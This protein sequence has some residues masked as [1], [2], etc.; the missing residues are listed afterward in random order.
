MLDAL[1]R[2]GLVERTLVS[3]QYMRSLVV[4]REL[5][6]ALR[7][8]WSVPRV[9]KD[10][11]A[12]PLL[13]L[14]AYAGL[15]HVRRRLPRVA[16]G[17][18]RAGRCDALMTHWRL[19]SPQLVEAVRRGRRRPLR[20]DG[21]R[22]APHPRARGD[23][24]HRRDHER[25]APVRRRPRA[26]PR[27]RRVV[28]PRNARPRGRSRLP[29]RSGARLPPARTRG[30]RS[31]RRAWPCRGASSRRRGHVP[32][33]R[34]LRH[35]LRRP[36][37]PRAGAAASMRAAVRSRSPP[38]ARATSSASWRCSTTSSR[39]ATVEAIDE[40]EALAILGGDMR[41]LMHEHAAIAVKLAVVARATAAGGER[42]ARQPVLPDRPEPRRGGAGPARRA[43]AG[44]GGARRATCRSPPRRPT[45]PSSPAPRASP[46]AA[47]SPC[48]SAPGVISQGRG[49]LVVHD[50]P[51][52]GRLCLL[53]R[54][55]SYGGVVV[56][57]R[58]GGGHHAARPQPRARAAQGR[59]QRRRD[60]ARRPPRARSARRPA[61]RPT[62]A[63]CSATCA[64]PTG[65]A[66][67]A[68][69]RPSISTSASSFPATPPT[70]TTRSTRR[71]GCPCEEARTRLS[72]PGEREMIERALSI[73]AAN[74]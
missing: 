53:S 21:R 74:G 27:R 13:R 44:R 17:H 49:R 8:G 40:L 42:A 61:S 11:T 73:L 72:Y 63:T 37:R 35:L 14:P 55:S 54:R 57:G 24:R 47:S 1:R 15:F 36:Q 20:L 19:V 5:E 30:A 41:R 65:V 67:G 46:P 6:P 52:L 2:H 7:L 60:A 22:R 29:A 9:K 28:S 69:P 64:T 4:L 18:L 16:A 33:G 26:P 71:A 45:S 62:C 39:S 58:R 31:G 50:P 43:G 10:Y 66:A 32:R 51:A 3:T 34:R 59:P 56:R 38:S 70:T 25:P 48:S 23:R 68:W 12:S